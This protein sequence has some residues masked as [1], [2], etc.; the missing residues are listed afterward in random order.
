VRNKAKALANAQKQLG[1]GNVDRA[2]KEYY[3]ILKEDPK[4]LRVR[5]KIGELLARK[6]ALPEAIKEFAV[7]AEAYERGGFYPKAVAIYKQILR[8]EPKMM[9]WHLSLGE[10]YQQLAH[11]S[12][13]MEHF[14]IVAQHYETQGSV[15]ER[16]DIYKRLIRINPNAIDY[17]ERLAALY[18]KEA[19]T[20]GAVE[21][22]RT[23]ADVV[24]QR[25]D[26]EGL[27]Q[28]HEKMSELRPSD[29]E[30]A[31]KLADLYLDKGDAKKALAKLQFCFRANPQDTETLN[32]LADA[33]VD[34][35]EVGKATAVL[36][37][38]AQ[39]YES[40]GYESYRNQVYDRIAQ[41][42]PS[43]AESTGASVLSYP[44]ADAAVEG[45]ALSLP[46][47][48]SDDITRSLLEVDV[49]MSYGLPEKAQSCL[50]KLLA[51]EPEC[52]EARRQ[53][54]RVVMAADDE[55]AAL[56]QITSLY[57]Q[58]MNKS[59]YKVA[60][61]CLVRTTEL[62]PEDGGARQRLEAF[63]EAMGD[64]DV[65]E[66]GAD[67]AASVGDESAADLTEP[68]SGEDS[69][70]G[71]MFDDALADEDEDEDAGEDGGD[72]FEFD[73]EEMAKLVAEFGG[74]D[75][76]TATL[77]ESEGAAESDN[78]TALERGRAL[79]ERGEHEA[80]ALELR[81]ALQDDDDS[82]EAMLLLGQALCRSGD[83]RGAVDILKKLLSSRT[84]GTDQL[85]AGMF[86]LAEAYEAA[87]N[88]KG[89]YKIYKRVVDQRSDFG[90][91]AARDRALALESELG[92]N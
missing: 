51:K 56:V 76:A 47:E 49:Y 33:F 13:A 7:V 90:D 60:R 22:W 74:S 88:A 68:S 25:R 72:D 89:A 45:L 29:I 40:I 6:G 24:D 62:F 26:S 37:E 50:E 66:G 27:I 53:L 87:G 11:T 19:D 91:G 84:A 42:D 14:N 4:D 8:Y 21:V 41:L 31:R 3:S 52:Y 63:E 5:Q 39:I 28:A 10:L 35:G 67:A 55:A 2:L 58:A 46:D 59:D 73:D 81:V 78:L 20:M 12:D 57:E 34:L 30:I 15:R 71:S 79:F 16:I 9:R 17:S 43:A 1:R 80:A 92:I 77:D 85:L 23:F 38:L 70:I 83:V 82:P 44:V 54:L 48:T 75:S 69:E 65:H 64:L 61:A 18:V 86:H 32:L 36:K